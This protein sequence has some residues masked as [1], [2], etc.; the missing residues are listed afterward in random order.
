VV[1]ARGAQLPAHEG[2]ISSGST[3]S[4]SHFIA[5]L[6]IVDKSASAC[7]QRCE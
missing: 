4:G 6:A 2:A 1:V 7:E 3:S 5:T